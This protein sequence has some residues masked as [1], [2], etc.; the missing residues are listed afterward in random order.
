MGHTT[1]H[2]ELFTFAKGIKVS[3]SNDRKA[4]AL[5]TDS[6]VEYMQ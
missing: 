5:L 1:I 4:L 3:K 6:L 2:N